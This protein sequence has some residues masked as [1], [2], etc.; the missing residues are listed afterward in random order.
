[1]SLEALI[2]TY[3]YWAVLAGTFLEGET[4]LVLGGFAAHRGYLHLPGVILVAFIGS[5]GGD[6]FY[7][8]MGRWRGQALI[9]KW[10]A[11]LDRLA[12]VNRLIERYHTPIILGSRFMYG[13]R[14]AF[15]V[16]IGLSRVKAG[17]FIMLNA[18]SALI[19]ST[20]VATGGYLFGSALEIM[21]GNL[22]HYERDIILVVCLAG[23]LF[24]GFNFYRRKKFKQP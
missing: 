19:W 3:G 16:A 10:P 9:E 12:R 8:L 24:W 13:L 2:Q 20:A 11:L 7:F 23:I 15:P 6:Q 4:I 18:L 22:K 14:I 17:R 21:L 1:M 5:F